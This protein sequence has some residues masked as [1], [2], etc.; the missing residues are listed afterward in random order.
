MTLV[1]AGGTQTSTHNIKIQPLMAW[2][3]VRKL[4]S[5]IHFDLYDFLSFSGQGA[6][7]MEIQ[8]CRF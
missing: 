4:L 3:V 1:F 7:E 6:C 5:H 2:A 8:G